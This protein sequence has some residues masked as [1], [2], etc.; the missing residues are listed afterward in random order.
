MDLEE[1]R[2]ILARASPSQAREHN[3][4]EILGFLM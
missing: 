2:Y 4:E 1:E 3:Y